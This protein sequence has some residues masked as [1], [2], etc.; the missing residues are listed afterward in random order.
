MNLSRILINV[1]RKNIISQIKFNKLP[2]YDRMTI[3]LM[4]TSLILGT[5]TYTLYSYEYM[6]DEREDK[7]EEK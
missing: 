1:Y 4:T 3:I 5:T 7:Q 6:E 2:I